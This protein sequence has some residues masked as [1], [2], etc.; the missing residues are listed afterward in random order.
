MREVV[1]DLWNYADRG[2]IA[3]TTNGYVTRKGLAV[4]GQG[5]ARQAGERY[6]DLPGVLGAMIMNNGNHVHEL[7]GRMVSFPVEHSPWSLPDLRLIGQSACELRRLA[8]RR[9]WDL[10]VVPRPGCGGGGLD[11]KSVAPV[12]APWF[13]DRFHVISLG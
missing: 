7:M 8:D 4:L 13:D 9:N 1:G 5:V 6:P 12:I 2:I 11:W 3:I 10:V